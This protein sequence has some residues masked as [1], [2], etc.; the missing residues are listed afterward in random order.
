M[1]CYYFIILFFTLHI[2][3]AQEIHTAFKSKQLLKADRFIGVDELD[4]IFYLNGHTLYKQNKNETLTYSNVKLGAIQ[5]VN[6]QNP[7][8]IILFYKDFNTVIILDNKLNELTDTIDFTNE[9]LFSYVQFVSPS[10]ENNL[11]LLADDNKIR[12]YDYQ[13]HMIKFET[14]AINFYQEAF[15]PVSIKSNY[16]FIWVF[17]N[18]GVMQFNEYGSFI[19]YSTLTNHESVYPYQKGFIYLNHNDLY[20]LDNNK[21]YTVFIE[22]RSSFKDIYIN[23]NSIY[24]FDGTYLYHYNIL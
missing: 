14:Q 9:S 7:F 20:Y 13:K 4:N 6:F 1:R 3:S 8:K 22:P 16:K 12:L 5:S 24:N 23:K 15:T 10:S 19:K 18:T 17:S 21:Q 2:S 11:W